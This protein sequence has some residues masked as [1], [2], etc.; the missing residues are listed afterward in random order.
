MPTV[1][2]YGNTQVKTEALPGVR[3]TAAPTEETFGVSGGN[4]VAAVGL[5][6]YEDEMLRQD[7]VAVLEA[8][9]KLS[10][11]ENKR[12]YDP[13]EGALAKKGKDA[14]GLP[15]AVGKDFDTFR[16]E[17]RGTLSTERQRVAFDRQAGSRRSDIDK[18]LARHVFAEVR[19]FDNAETENYLLNARQAAIANAGDPERV[20]IEIERQTAAVVDFANRNGFGTEYVKQ[21]TAQVRSDTHVGVV[22]RM[23]ANG[24]DMTAKAYLD[25]VKPEIAG[26]DIAKVE[27]WLEEGALRG[28]S[29]RDA[30]TIMSTTTT[31]EAALEKAKSISDPKLRDAVEERVNR[32]YT[33][34]K[35]ADREQREQTMT[36]A[37]NIIDQTG[38]IDKIPPATW[39]SMT[40]SERQAL[41]SY[42]K[43]KESGGESKT[44]LGAFYSLITLAS[45]DATKDAFARTN[46][47]QYI[48][49]L[50]PSDFKQLAGIQ[51]SIRKGDGKAA[52]TLDGFLTNMQ[53][54]DN[55][56]R[57][58]GINPAEKDQ[59]PKV[60]AFRRAVD[61]AVA[62]HERQTGKK[63]SNADIRSIADGLLISG[64]VPGSGW[65]VDDTKR[66]FELKEGESLVIRARDVP[67][68]D[69]LEIER[70]LRAQGRGV[71]DEAIVDA[72]TRYVM[73][74]Q[75]RTPA[76]AMPSMADKVPR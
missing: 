22:E 49:K 36:D 19:Q 3:L 44:D 50:S 52:E 67:R 45:S 63:A 57:E 25:R 40:V 6:L 70:E 31:R 48:H 14:F 10:E 42:A 9:R 5:K 62:R 66:A 72:Y 73:R 74:L 11:W 43:R 47:M 69:R 23:L 38:S 56:L 13:R 51:A 15:D 18:T 41:T 12:L 33:L 71:T 16:D 8:D 4:K 26:D 65:I 28:Q 17:L 76:P 46:L 68:S 32:Y 1:R 24:Q 54:V 75:G 2:G 53:V 55:T 39:Q 60:G 58:A 61:E 35:E 21:K 27:K 29:Q 64:K 7:Q 20:G 34:R 59:A 37:A 30:D